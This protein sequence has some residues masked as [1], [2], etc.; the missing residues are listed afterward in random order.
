MKARDI[1]TRK[2]VSVTPDT[3]AR[4]IAALLL[5]KRVSAV[6]VV[7][8]N[9]VAVGIVSKGDLIGKELEYEARRDWWLTVLA[10]GE[11]VNSDF[12][13]NLRSMNRVARD[14]MSSPVIA[15][16]EE[17]DVTEIARTLVAHNI[18]RV[19]VVGNGRTL[20]I[21][22]RGDILRALIVV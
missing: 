4:E 14:L 17:A 5:K 11:A 16:G 12:L 7:D 3:P 8:A 10:E 19:P 15:V 18:N 2:V 21:V 13:A 22:S 9:G 20:G 1:M 6:P